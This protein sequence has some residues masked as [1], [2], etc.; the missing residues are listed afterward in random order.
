[1]KE[2]E[3]KKLYN[4]ITNVNEAYMEEIWNRR[5]K[6]KFSVWAKW[7]GMA[8]CL[9]LGIM[10]AYAAVHFFTA[11]GTESPPEILEKK[12]FDVSKTDLVE[13][14]EGKTKKVISSYESGDA[15]ACYKSVDNGSCKYSIPL[16][17]AMEKYGDTVLYKVV[18]D[19]F[20]NNDVLET[21]SEIVKSEIE[22]L[23]EIGYTAEL[24]Q[25]MEHSYFVLCAAQE[26]LVNFAVQEN[27]GYL[28]YLYEERAK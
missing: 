19:V 18:V 7:G 27:Y 25:D 15:T 26:Q 17:N 12:E 10:A 28:F 24:E 16:R 1:M 22:R 20:S 11:I 23:S 9:F 3:A 2:K 13:T 6:R 4:S 14:D 8:A 21:N 5:E